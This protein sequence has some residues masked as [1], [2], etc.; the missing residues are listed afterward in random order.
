MNGYILKGL[1]CV[2]ILIKILGRCY[3]G[4]IKLW[5]SLVLGN[6]ELG[7]MLQKKQTDLL[8]AF[9]KHRITELEAAMQESQQTLTNQDK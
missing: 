6:L 1:I 8:I 3:S 9:Y 7:Q 2:S 4:N 5:L